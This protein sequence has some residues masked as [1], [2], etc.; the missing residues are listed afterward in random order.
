MEQE[1]QEEV[2]FLKMS[3]GEDL[4]CMLIGDEE[5]YLFVTQPYRIEMMQSPA[6]MTVTTAIMRWIPFESL[7]E[8]TICLDKRNILTYM[9]VD[10]IVASRYMSTI[11]QQSKR[12]REEQMNRIRQMALSQVM[13][14]IANTSGTLH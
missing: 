3:S 1:E 13:R 9:I 10:D 7:M 12:D 2:Y 5:D 6:T 4:L 14:T 8:E 11:N